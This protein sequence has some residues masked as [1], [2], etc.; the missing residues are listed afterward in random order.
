M[1]IMG[2]CVVT[3]ATLFQRHATKQN[4]VVNKCHLAKQKLS[5]PRLELA[6][7]HMAANLADNIKSE[8]TNLNIR[9]AF[10]WAES[11]VW[12]HW[13]NKKNYIQFVNNKVDKIKEK[14]YISRRHITTNENPAGIG[15]MG[16]F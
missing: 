9:N 16:V 8:L 5:I 13:L 10:G 3:Y 14:D 11:T 2:T 12:L 4:I 1:C 15:S 6:A 7:T